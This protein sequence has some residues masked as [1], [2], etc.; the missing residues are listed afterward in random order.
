LGALVR[1]LYLGKVR[2][3][4]IGAEL[5]AQYDRFLDLVG[6]PPSLVNSHH[7]VQVFPP[8]GDILVQ[9][10]EKQRPLPYVRRVLEPWRPLLR[11][12]GARLKRALL[13]VVGRRNARRQQEAGFPGNDWLAGITDPP[14]VHD[15]RHLT[16]WLTC[17]PGRVVELTCH[18]GHLDITLL[19]RDA[20]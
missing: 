5:R 10:L 1:R 2:S 4:E 11:V 19:G 7:H 16:R 8:I 13:S 18:P 20:S 17:V 15:P 9:V 3:A 12:P 6:R 14:W